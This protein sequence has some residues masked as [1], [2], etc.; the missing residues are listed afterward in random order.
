MDIFVLGTS[1]VL[2]RTN[3]VGLH[4]NLPIT[5]ATNLRNQSL[6]LIRKPTELEA[7]INNI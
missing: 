3:Y 4:I 2:T 1:V 5:G 6:E 7:N